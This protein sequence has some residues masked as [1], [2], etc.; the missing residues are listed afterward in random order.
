MPRALLLLQAFQQSGSILS[1]LRGVVRRITHLEPHDRA[2]VV[3]RAVVNGPIAIDRQIDRGETE[4]P[5]A[6][7]L[8]RPGDDLKNRGAPQVSDTRQ[9]LL[10]LPR[11]DRSRQECQR[12]RVG[13]LQRVNKV[14]EDRWS[15]SLQQVS[16]RCLPE[17]G[18][19]TVPPKSSI[20]TRHPPD[21][22]ARPH[23]T[24]VRVDVQ[25]HVVLAKRRIG[26]FADEAQQSPNLGRH[27]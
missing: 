19:A 5:I 3:S 22:Q 6:G 9:Q 18:V 13:F 7:L 16:M 8:G 27:N 26:C 25:I 17:R 4:N 23:Q 14:L 1:H 11:I 2:D 20:K 10:L 24:D 15:R 12:I 21:G